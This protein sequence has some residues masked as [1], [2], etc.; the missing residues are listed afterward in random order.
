MF[1]TTA[2]I[3]GVDDQIIVGAK[4]GYALMQ[5]STGKLEYIKKVWDERDGAGKEQR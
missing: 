2:E 1:S 5:R 3:D 4:C